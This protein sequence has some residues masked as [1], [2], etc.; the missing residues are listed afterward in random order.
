MHQQHQLQKLRIASDSQLNEYDPNMHS[1][2]DDSYVITICLPF[3]SLIL[4][5]YLSN[6]TMK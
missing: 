2:S 6:R 1:D 3:F 5:I 4:P